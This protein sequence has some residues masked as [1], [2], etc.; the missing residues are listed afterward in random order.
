MTTPHV[1][2][3]Q[4]SPSKRV[5]QR[6][7]IVLASLGAAIMAPYAHAEDE[8][9]GEPTTS[10]IK[11]GL[12]HLDV[13]EV[14]LEL[15][16]SYDYR[17]VRSSRSGRFSS[18][19][20]NRDARFSEQISFTLDGDII[21]PN[22]FHW[23]GRIG[24]G[25]TQEHYY[26]SDDGRSRE[27]SETGELLDFD[28]TFDALREKPLTFSGY[29]RRS[30]DR[31]PRRFLPSL[32]E[33]R[34]EAGVAAFYSKDRWTL[35]VG[36]DWTDVD[37]TG[38]RLPEDDEELTTYR[39]YVDSKWEFTD[40][41]SLRLSYDHGREKSDY[42]GS[43]IDFDTRRDE[44]RL[45]HELRFGAGDRHRLD[46][47][48]RFND[49]RGDLARD[50][51]E[52]VPRLTLRHSDEFETR[53]RYGYYHLEQDK[54][55]LTRHKLDWQAIYRPTEKWRLTT[56]WFWLTERVDDDVETHEFGG[57][58][59]TGYRQE[60][61]GGE[62]SA[63]LAL[64]ADRSRTVG[65]AGGRVVRGEAHVLDSAAPSFLRN[66]NVYL[67]TVLVYNSTRTRIYVAGRDYILTMVGRRLYLRRLLTGDIL[68]GEIV[69]VD[70]EYRIPA[71]SV[72]DSYRVDF[73]MEQAFEFGLTPY[74]YFE[75]RRQ[76]TDGSFGTPVFRDNTE[77][78]RIGARYQ[79][80][81]WSAGAE[82]ELFHDSI[83]PYDAW[84]LN[85]SWSIVR[86][87]RHSVDAV[88]R[89]SHYSFTGDIDQRDVWFFDAELTD[90]MQLSPY[91]AATL[92]TAY[93]H[94]DDSIDG[95]TNGVDVELGVQFTRGHLQVEVTA[96]YDLLSIADNRDQGYGLWLTIRRD[97]SH[98]LPSRRGAQR[99]VASREE[100]VGRTP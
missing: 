95:R 24:F 74:Y 49:E 12:I 75:L 26:E 18:T 10:R 72:I 7:I 23:Q 47:Y 30:R 42:Q 94:E 5:R 59:D 89:Y 13:T 41:H 19:H 45:D 99:Q 32:L 35:E 54:L 22:L 86:T 88:A 98:L 57:R 21:D 34:T 78:H 8:D 61:W 63:N 82:L 50:E 92:G 38:N 85:G 9:E 20:V 6:W 48:V 16:A 76:F 25:L 51:I 40:R 62:F 56:D 91:L 68:P 60:L 67:P 46:T 84:H 79:R 65:S 71:G 37:R 15:E 93:R 4:R 66:L 44:L 81:R 43:S 64:Q 3:N 53:Y 80:Q 96:E 28:L 87:T 58:L 77:R 55:D 70:Y 2:Y 97:L 17:R 11:P 73:S 90:R 52:F 31:V 33:D 29:A 83:E 39:F 27:E 14:F 1:R 100:G 36:F 69:Y